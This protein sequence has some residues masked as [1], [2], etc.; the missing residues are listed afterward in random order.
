MSEMGQMVM[1]TPSSR[2]SKF[3]CNLKMKA[4]AS[5]AASGLSIP[6]IQIDSSS[7]AWVSPDR[8]AST[9]CDGMALGNAVRLRCPQA[10]ERLQKPQ[11]PS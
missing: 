9:D 1:A 2:Q 6:M 4:A 8:L 11:S 5:A 3:G 10:S 7:C